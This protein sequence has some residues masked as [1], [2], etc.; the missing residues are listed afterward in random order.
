[1]KSV[2]KYNEIKKYTF[3]LL[4]FPFQGLTFLIMNFLWEVSNYASLQ[5]SCEHVFRDPCSL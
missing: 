2:H 4:C 5:S 1:M 3:L